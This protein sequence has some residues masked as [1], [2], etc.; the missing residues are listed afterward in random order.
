MVTTDSFELWDL[1]TLTKADLICLIPKLDGPDAS[2][3]VN[4]HSS[5]KNQAQKFIFDSP[6]P[7]RPIITDIKKNDR[8]VFICAGGMQNARNI[9]CSLLETN[10]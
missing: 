2:I 7:S 8:M 1:Q 4:T 6:F 3:S 10:R 5:Q 9:R